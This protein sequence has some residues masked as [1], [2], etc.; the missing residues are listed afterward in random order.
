M[1]DVNVKKTCYVFQ[2]AIENIVYLFLFEMFFPISAL[3]KAFLINFYGLNN[4]HKIKNGKIIN[5][6][7]PISIK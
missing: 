5:D 6:R 4:I 7:K 1:G 2:I 3:F